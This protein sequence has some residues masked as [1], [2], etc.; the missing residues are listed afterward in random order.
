MEA[1]FSGEMKVDWYLKE[2]RLSSIFFILQDLIIPRLHSTLQL[3]TVLITPK[4]ICILEIKN[5]TGEFHSD[6]EG[7]QFY[8]IK[9]DGVKE[10]QR[11][12]E[13]QLRRA[14]RTIQP[15]LQQAQIDLPLI[16]IIVFA[17]R[18]GVYRRKT[19]TFPSGFTG[20]TKHKRI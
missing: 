15:L 3:D 7:Y 12:P 11:S 17:S 6:S 20:S 18:S 10:P 13:I 1:G 19:K 4:F 9:K 2:L 8:R 16:G 5:M 14:V